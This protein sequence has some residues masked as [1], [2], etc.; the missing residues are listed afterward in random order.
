MDDLLTATL[1]LEVPRI[2]SQ[3]MMM[4]RTQV[5]ELE[6]QVL[7]V[8]NAAA[9]KQMEDIDGEVGRQVR[10]KV[11]SAISRIAAETM[12]ETEI[13]QRLQRVVEKQLIGVIDKMEKDLKDD[14]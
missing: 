1:S 8:V 12:Y 14:E 13:Y 9:L 6:S 7:E 2:K 10:E 3:I 5:A 11:N 4:V